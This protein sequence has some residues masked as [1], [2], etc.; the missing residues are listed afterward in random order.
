MAVQRQT[1]QALRMRETSPRDYDRPS[2]R[3]IGQKACWKKTIDGSEGPCEG[4]VEAATAEVG[5]I[6]GVPAGTALCLEHG[7]LTD[8][9]LELKALITDEDRTRW[10]IGRSAHVAEMFEDVRHSQKL[11]DRE[12]GKWGGC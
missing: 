12:D 6:K 4:V 8:E 1:R 11:V 9:E 5:L 10:S 7:F 2:T 3:F